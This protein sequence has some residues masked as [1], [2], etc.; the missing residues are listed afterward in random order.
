MLRDEAIRLMYAKRAELAMSDPR[1]LRRAYDAEART[2]AKDA[3]RVLALPM[4]QPATLCQL[5]GS[6]R[7]VDGAFC[8]ACA[9]DLKDAKMI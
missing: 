8:L 5:C 3:Q 1:L 4:V 7:A 2:F 9:D 6:A